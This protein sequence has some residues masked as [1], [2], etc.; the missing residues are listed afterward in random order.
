MVLT[1][2]IQVRDLRKFA[3]TLKLS[4][5]THEQQADD[6]ALEYLS[7]VGY[8]TV[9]AHGSFLCSDDGVR[10]ERVYI[11]GRKNSK[12]ILPINLK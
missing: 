5:Y 9:N 11:G 8:S 7:M 4:F 3:R 6:I 1:K 2:K 12:W 10:E